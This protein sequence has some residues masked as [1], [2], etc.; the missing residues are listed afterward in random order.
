MFTEAINAL[1]W[2]IVIASPFII[3]LGASQVRRRTRQT[4]RRVQAPKPVSRCWDMGT[5]DNV[6]EVTVDFGRTPPG[7]G[8]LIIAARQV[9]SNKNGKRYKLLASKRNPTSK[10]FY[11]EE[12]I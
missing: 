1:S 10:I 7:P 11:F 2:F 3:F 8:I 5:N 6:I 4:A 9:L 12:V